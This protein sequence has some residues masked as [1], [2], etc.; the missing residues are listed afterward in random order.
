MGSQSADFC[1]NPGAKLA[2]IL[3]AF[4]AVSGTRLAVR[5][6]SVRP[7]FSPFCNP[8]F[9]QDHGARPGQREERKIVPLFVD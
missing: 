7:L 1:L 3:D 5:A 2:N 6:P 9:A 8:A 4:T